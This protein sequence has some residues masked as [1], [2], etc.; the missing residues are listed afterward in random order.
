MSTKT[1]NYN[2]VKPEMQ[3]IIDIGVI[4]ENMDIIDAELKALGNAPASAKTALADADTVQIND[5]A[6]SNKLKKITWANIKTALASLFAAK[7]HTHSKSQ[8]TD[9]PASIAPTS[10]VATH[11]TGGS[12]ALS[13]ADIGA[14][15]KVGDTAIDGSLTMENLLLK[16]LT[17]SG[18]IYIE[19]A[20]NRV[21]IGYSNSQDNS[22]AML[23]VSP[24]AINYMDNSGQEHRIIHEGN[25]SQYMGVAAAS[26]V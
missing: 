26:L 7:T 20:M 24:Y 25:M 17:Y 2:L 19:P 13:A 4:N 12:D 8:I 6:D 22:A 10:H 9:F 15:P 5:S 16:Y 21:E 1:P 3:D 18:H 11:K 14:V 23:T